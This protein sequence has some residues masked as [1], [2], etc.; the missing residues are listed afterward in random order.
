M[1]SM[2]EFHRAMQCNLGSLGIYMAMI[3]HVD[4][5]RYCAHTLHSPAELSVM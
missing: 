5:N 2:L 3:V 1:H 4:Y